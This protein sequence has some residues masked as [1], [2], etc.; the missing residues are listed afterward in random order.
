MRA[1]DALQ[2]DNPNFCRI[3]ALAGNAKRK[4]CARASQVLSPNE[5]FNGAIL[6]SE[7]PL[8]SRNNVE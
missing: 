8:L 4:E 5:C 6:H 7:R 3:E 1:P 2:L